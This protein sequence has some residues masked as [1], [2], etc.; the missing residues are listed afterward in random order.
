MKLKS[1]RFTAEPEMRQQEGN[2]HLILETAGGQIYLRKNVFDEDLH[3][4]FKHHVKVLLKAT[5]R[6]KAFY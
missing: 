1:L 6:K 5:E 3:N 2:L 4:S